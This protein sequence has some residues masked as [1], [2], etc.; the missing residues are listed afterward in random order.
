MTYIFVVVENGRFC[1]K[2]FASLDAALVYIHSRYNEII[3]DNEDYMR[4]CNETCV[5]YLYADSGVK[6]FIHKLHL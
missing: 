6:I 1:K 4:Y 5:R 2:A 3:D